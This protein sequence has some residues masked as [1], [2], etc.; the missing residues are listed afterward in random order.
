MFRWQYDFLLLQKYCNIP[1]DKIRY[2]APGNNILYTVDTIINEGGEPKI[3]LYDLALPEISNDTLRDYPIK[4]IV[5]HH[6]S[7]YNF[8]ANQIVN[9]KSDYCT[10][11]IVWLDLFDTIITAPLFLKS[12][13]KVTEVYYH[14]IMTLKSLSSTLDYRK[15]SMFTLQT[16]K[17]PGRK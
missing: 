11:G 15:F 13:T 6:I 5:D 12:L 17:T 16:R 8:S 7:T 1:E 3:G 2:I 9:Y 14:W 10:C 4:K